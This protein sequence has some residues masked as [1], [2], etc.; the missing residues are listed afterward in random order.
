MK[1]DEVCD[2]LPQFAMIVREMSPFSDRFAIEENFVELEKFGPGLN[3]WFV[4][5]LVFQSVVTRVSNHLK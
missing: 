3:F 5:L 2:E 1:M 4:D